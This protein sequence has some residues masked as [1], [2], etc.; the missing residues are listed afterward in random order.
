MPPRDFSDEAMR[1]PHLVFTDG[2]WE[3]G[4]ATA[5][6]FLYDAKLKQIVTQAIL[7]PGVLIDTWRQEVGEQL[8]C[9]IELFAFLAVRFCFAD[10]MHNRAVIAWVD[11]E[12]ARFAASKCT[13][14]SPSL[15]AMP[16]VLQALE[17]IKPSL[18]WIERIASFSNPAD[19]P[20][21]GRG[22]QCSS[23]RRNF[24]GTAFGNSSG[25]RR[26]HSE[27]H[28]NALCCPSIF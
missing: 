16:R 20:S 13:A 24:L 19:D 3:Q 2:A 11:N 8:I 26:R 5:G 4:E 18:I 6:L 1:S 23:L 17:G 9:Q 27:A 15:A 14:S 7:V 21:R 28:Q 25:G 12:A 22:T 10:K